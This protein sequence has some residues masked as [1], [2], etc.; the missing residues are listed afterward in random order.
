MLVFWHFQFIKV[1]IHTFPRDRRG[2][3][4]VYA[5]E[6][7]FKQFF[8]SDSTIASV[9]CRTS[10]EYN[11]KPAFIDAENGTVLTF[12]KTEE[13]SNRIA[14]YFLS[15]I[16]QSS[17][18]TENCRQNVAALLSE[19]SAY[20]VPIW[21]GLSKIN[22]ITALINT[23][24]RLEP[25]AHCLKASNAK[26]II[27][28]SHM[29]PVIDDLLKNKLL[30]KEVQIFTFDSTDVENSFD[31]TFRL[32]PISKPDFDT[33]PAAS[34]KTVLYVFTSGTTGLPKPAVINQG[35]V[36]GMT[37]MPHHCFNLNHTDRL[38]VTMP[39]YH[40]AGGVLGAG[41][42]LALGCTSVIRRKFSASHFWSDCVHFECT[43]SQYIGEIGRYLLAQPYRNEESQHSIRLMYGN[44]MKK[45]IWRDFIRR[46]NVSKIG[47]IY[48]CTEGNTTIVNLDCTIGACGFLPVYGAV[49]DLY[50]IR[51]VRF[52]EEKNDVIRDSKTGLCIK[53]R[54]G[55][56][57]VMVGKIIKNS[58][59]KDFVGYVSAEE[60]SRKTITNVF[61]KGDVAF[62]TG[63]LLHM[64]EMGY[65]YFKDRCGDTFR[66][67]GENVST[68]EVEAIIEKLSG[69]KDA[70]VY[71]VEIPNHDGKAGAVCLNDSKDEIKFDRFLAKL[72]DS[73][74]SYAVPIFVRLK[75][76]LALT[77]TFKYQKFDL[78]K[79]GFDLD[80]C[81]NDTIFYLNKKMNTYS[82]LTRDI[83][84]DIIYGRL[85]F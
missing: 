30:D 67:K 4:V 52:D 21:L 22:V 55:E 49:S 25:L 84:Q 80:K 53:C 66:W 14:N 39:M 61:S 57:G 6:R 79:T 51:L 46:F 43:A 64:D 75:K 27:V 69:Y 85:T 60:S 50:P 81:G 12:E 59:M 8:D 17:A 15:K 35:R 10:A 2:F 20:Y 26:F 5:V 62:S 13:F 41:A 9:F 47:E 1:V 40:T 3:Q 44:G 18:S 23:N 70:V 82:P 28:S 7:D 37:R 33:G 83:A 58:P 36:Y 16:H 31:E 76:D 56:S 71:A 68:V 34:K 73:L 11:E 63:D 19:N 29:K 65:L 72:K 77:G 78:Q 38:Y 54:P 24:L 48:G 32:T 45:E 74:P 42:T